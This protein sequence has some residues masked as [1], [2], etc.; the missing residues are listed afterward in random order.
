M[1][2]RKSPMVLGLLAATCVNETPAA[3]V[4]PASS[5][6]ERREMP[7]DFAGVMP[8]P[9]PPGQAIRSEFA[10]AEAK[11]TV[12]AYVLFARRHPGD[13]LAREAERRA[14]AL[15]AQKRD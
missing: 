6:V 13:P 11:G 12:E 10:Q 1:P 9:A 4:G 3:A 15:A 5:N 8:P 2:H 14:R 7:A